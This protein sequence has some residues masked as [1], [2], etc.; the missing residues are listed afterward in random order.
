MRPVISFPGGT[1][2]SQAPCTMLEDMFDACMEELSKRRIPRDLVLYIL[3]LVYPNAFVECEVKSFPDVRFTIAFAKEICFDAF[4]HVVYLSQNC[5]MSAAWDCTSHRL[6]A[7]HSTGNRP[8]RKTRKHSIWNPL[9]AQAP[10]S[11]Y[12]NGI[13]SVVRFNLPVSLAFCQ[14]EIYICDRNNHSIR[15]YDMTS[16]RVDD[17]ANGVSQTLLMEFNGRDLWM[18]YFPN[19]I[20]CIK[21]EV[22]ND[23]LVIS[24][25]GNNR[26]VKMIPGNAT[27]YTLAGKSGEVGCADG[28]QWGDARFDWPMGMHEKNQ[29]ILVADGGNHRIRCLKMRENKIETISGGAGRGYRD[30]SVQVAKFNNPRDVLWYSDEVIL[31]ADTGNHCIRRINL[32]TGMVDTVCGVA[33][34]WNGGSSGSIRYPRLRSPVSMSIVHVPGHKYKQV[35]VVE[36]GAAGDKQTKLLTFKD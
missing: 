9:P 30:G 2:Q 35:L 25:T 27:I 7:G 24:D 22:G 34:R 5:L 23:L 32:E 11:G 36:E 28:P 19:S 10:N 3:R 31:V 33:E 8:V 14:S 15:K 21:D 12:I 6:L 18:L 17:F 16:G 13:G 26:I 4:E 1:L 20:I 29:L